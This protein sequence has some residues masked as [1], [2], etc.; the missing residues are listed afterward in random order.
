MSKVSSFSKLASSLFA[1]MQPP[2]PTIVS[3]SPVKTTE[4]AFT[5]TYL[6]GEW[7]RN[8]DGEGFSGSGSTY[9]NTK[10][11][12]GLLKDLL[13]A[14]NITSIVDVG[15]G[16]WTFSQHVDWGKINYTGYDIVKH[17][18]EK[19]C[20][21][22]ASSTIQ[23]FHGNAINMD[24]KPADLLICKDVL[25]HLPNSDI[26]NFLPQ[27]KKFKYCL[28]TNDVDPGTFTSNNMSIPAGAYRTVDIMQAPFNLN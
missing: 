3:T 28:I 21:K 26:L 8:Q 18:I 9:E 2:K 19:N 1:K 23:F 13:K 15:C 5:D 11:Y 4:E 10:L 6:S 27:L 24:L 14:L 16:D 7:G 12:R 22:F 17:V 20:Q 25:Q